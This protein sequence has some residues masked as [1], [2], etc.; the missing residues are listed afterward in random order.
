[1]INPGAIKLNKLI[2][3]QTLWVLIVLIYGGFVAAKAVQEHA[4]IYDSKHYENVIRVMDE[5]SRDIYYGQKCNSIDLSS[6]APEPMCFSLSTIDDGTMLFDA[7]TPRP[8]AEKVIKNYNDVA[9]KFVTIATF[10]FYLFFLLLWLIPSIIFYPFFEWF[11]DGYKKDYKGGI[12]SI[13]SQTTDGVTVDKVENLLK[14]Y[15]IFLEGKGKI[16]NLALGLGFAIL[17]GIFDVISPPPYS[18]IMIYLFP[19]ALTTWFAGQSAGFFI[20]VICIA[21]WSQTNQ[22]TDL[23]VFSWNILSTLSIYFIVSIMLTKLRC[24]WEDETALSRTDQLTGVMNRRAFEEIVVYEILSLQRQNSPFSLAYLDLDNFKEVNDNL[25]HKAG[26]E[27]LKA[28]VACLKENLRRTDLVARIGGDEFTI[29][30]PATDQGAVK[31]VIQKL[32]EQLRS[33][34]ER[35]A[36]PTTISIGVVTSVDSNCDLETTVSL[37]DKLMYE[38]KI[39]GKNDVNYMTIPLEM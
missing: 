8:E 26:D 27:L 24:M 1:M 20:T 21:F 9:Y 15:F 16:F 18:Y 39:N 5:Q 36:W 30:F 6:D 32:L 3:R 35:K 14:R 10:K 28:V 31:L 13:T 7:S 22:Q 37:A 34:S 19:I 17:F 4:Y 11:L 23:L 12:E 25:G 2:T 33:L 29:F 38:V